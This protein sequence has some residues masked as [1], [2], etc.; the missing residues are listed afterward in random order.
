MTSQLEQLGT[1]QRRLSLA[2]PL[3]QV[4]QQ[5]E[6]RLRD[7]G[8]T[9]RLPGFRPGK[10]PMRLI[11]QSYGAQVQSEVLGDS[12]NKVLGDAIDEHKLRVAGQPSIERKDGGPETEFGFTATFEV[13]P[14]ITLGDVST[15]KVERLACE[16][17]DAEVDRTIEVLRKQRATWSD[18]AAAAKDGDRVTIDF[19]GT[20]DG[21]EFQGGKADDFPFELG[22]GRML[23][24]FETGVRG[25]MAAE[26]REFDVAFPA[27]YG[28]Q[29]LAGKTAR[30]KVTVKKIEQAD[31][32]A[33]DA[34]FAKTLGVE[35]GDIT[36]LKAEIRSN[37]EREVAQR[38]RQRTKTSVLEALPALAEFE[39]PQSL[40]Q[41]E[42]EALAERTKADLKA[43]GMDVEKIPVPM[44][45]FKE[46]AEKRVRL[47]L[48]VGEIV[49][50]QNL[51]PK[52]D[53]IRKQ[54]EEMSAGYENPGEV[55]RYYF[56][57]KQRIAEVE[58]VVTE[59]NVVDWALGKAQVT[60]R[61]LPFDELMQNR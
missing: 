29:D 54:I 20:L 36:K 1:L 38:L 28:S 49:R 7:I 4:E 47:G 8:R 50:T 21:V 59:Q 39:I 13:Y 33:L 56:S 45:A 51:Q 17:S 6:K 58:A 26:V 19:V 11:A 61:Q 25:A 52:P 46:Q 57:D 34:E 30:F 60:D 24:D 14:E 9:A 5:V 40:V 15:L 12:V 16:V 44:D 32:P 18:S 23:P 53:Q 27:D 10:V 55:I 42:S 31:L 43:R 41:G 22:Q 35:D 48:L 37:I 2:V 3:A